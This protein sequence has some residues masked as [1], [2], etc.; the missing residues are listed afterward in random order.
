MSELTPAQLG[1]ASV[2]AGMCSTI[3]WESS[4]ERAVA[5]AE[6][7]VAE[8]GVDDEITA[9]AIDVGVEEATAEIRRLVK[10]LGETRDLETFKTGVRGLCEQTA[11]R[12]PALMNATSE[13]DTVFETAMAALLMDG[14]GNRFPAVSPL[15]SVRP[16]GYRP[17]LPVPGP[18]GTVKADA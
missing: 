12:L 2:Y 3:G 15:R 13:T 4:R 9:A 16:S 17:R 1:Q 11:R 8:T 10:A 6:T 14:P 18:P 7:Y 5:L